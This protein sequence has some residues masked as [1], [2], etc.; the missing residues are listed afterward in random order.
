VPSSTLSDASAALNTQI[1]TSRGES[2]WVVRRDVGDVRNEAFCRSTET[3]SEFPAGARSHRVV[4]PLPCS[5]ITPI[6]CLS[7][8][9]KGIHSLLTATGR[10]GQEELH[11]A[12]QSLRI[13]VA[14]SRLLVATPG[15]SSYRNN[16]IASNK[17]DDSGVAL[18]KQV[19]HSL[20]DRINVCCCRLSRKRRYAILWESRPSQR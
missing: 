6:L 11:T 3:R 15:L 9:R 10:T 8:Y 13:E 18:R 1:A 17:V 20:C 12:Q 7:L 2:H 16:S 19:R 14:L 5:A 4:G